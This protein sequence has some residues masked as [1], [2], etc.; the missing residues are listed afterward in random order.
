[1]KA[2]KSLGLA[3]T[4]AK[5]YVYLAKRGPLE[6][7][8]LAK[9]LKLTEQRICFSLEMLLTKGMVSAIPEL[10]TKYSAIALEKILD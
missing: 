4:E 9:T 8:D 10:T 3:E 7:K 6:E 1:M 5:V 2:L